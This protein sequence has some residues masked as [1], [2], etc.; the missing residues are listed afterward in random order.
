MGQ[1]L[2][3][4]DDDWRCRDDYFTSALSEFSLTLSFSWSLVA[5]ELD[6]HV[7]RQALASQTLSINT[8][9]LP[10]YSARN[11]TI[12]SGVLKKQSGISHLDINPSDNT[13]RKQW[14]APQRLSG[15]YLQTEH[16]LSILV[17]LACSASS[18]VQPSKNISKRRYL[19]LMEAT[20]TMAARLRSTMDRTENY[21]IPTDSSGS[22]APYH[23]IGFEPS[24]NPSGTCYTSSHSK[25]KTFWRRT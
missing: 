15:R 20:M 10:S 2:A 12:T 4:C 21:M 22:I 18:T 25:S 7:V 9:S 16:I 8:R 3:T 6:N 13:N 19:S 5:R 23:R 1:V 11:S 14:R 24:I 17:A